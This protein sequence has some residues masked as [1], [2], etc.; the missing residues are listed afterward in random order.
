MAIDPVTILFAVGGLQEVG[1][2]FDTIESRIIKL[3]QASTRSTESGARTR[4]K[5]AQGEA[6]S[7]IK[8]SAQGAEAVA[9]H[10][11]TRTTAAEKQAKTM[12]AIRRRSAEMAGRYAEQEAKKEI[13]ER[14]QAVK[15]VEKLEEYK[16]RVM[17]K[18][19]EMAGRAAEI[20]AKA[21][22]TARQRVTRGIGAATTRGARNVLGGAASLAIGGLAIGGGFAMADIAKKEL[23]A[24]KQAA[25]IVNAVTSGGVVPAGANVAN[26][27]GKA[28]QVSRETGMS[29]EDVQ[30]GT[31]A[32]VKSSK[33][34]DFGNAMANMGFFAKLAKTTGSDITDI[35]SGAGMMQS[36]NPKLQAPEMQQMLLDMLAQGK[37]GSRSLS[38]MVGLAGIIGSARGAYGGDTTANQRKLLGLT[39]L[40]APEAGSAEEAARG[41]KQMSL[42]VEKGKNVGLLKGWGVKYNE[43]G[44]VSDIEQMI[45]ATLSGTKG[46]LQGIG[47]VF[48]TRSGGLMRHMADTYNT[49]GGGDKGLAAAKAE[50]ATVTQA[51]TKPEELDAQFAQL[52]STPAEKF[53]KA[54]NDISEVVSQRLE[55]I[56]ASLADKMD[57]GGPAIEA[58]MTSIL[59]LAAWLLDNPWKGIGAAVS[60]GITKELAEAG[61]GA[62]VGKAIEGSI[63]ARLGGG[64]A[65]AAATL[66]IGIA[67]IEMLGAA[68][69]A[70]QRGGVADSTGA[71]N[72]ASNVIGAANNG[73]VTAKDVAATE[74][75]IKEMEA[76]R[77]TD[78]ESVATANSFFRGGKTLLMG[79]IGR[80]EE[81]A[82]AAGE[83]K[84]TEMALVRLHTA[85]DIAKAKIDA[86]AA[87]VASVPPPERHAP[88]GSPGRS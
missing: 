63:A 7:R 81:S 10:E 74:A 40:A 27:L 11:A 1:R 69:V 73:T 21:E 24:E 77:Q 36:Q 44:Q 13:R 4:V 58:L 22:E 18:S 50:M 75:K 34:G 14:E 31:L 49:A 15:Q 38:E 28:S 8:A 51:T 41:V 47:K 30:A 37:Q 56:L 72:V 16:R 43:H 42:Q 60:I 62:M 86:H 5:V 23:S 33:K 70:K 54:L 55:P 88:I 26:I 20:A 53:Q 25:L 32:Y 29:K 61:L 84:N 19:A 48:E 46:N 45:L 9:K 12:D 83:L 3:E 71:S 39:Q 64:I 66:A 52:M 17:L 78:K 6:E 59:D 35:A 76:K 57:K 2:S 68:D 87:S 82:R 67:T 79:N 85:L 80:E 65:V